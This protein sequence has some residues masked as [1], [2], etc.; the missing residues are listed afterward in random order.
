MKISSQIYNVLIYDEFITSPSDNVV[1]YIIGEKNELV[2]IKHINSPKN[3][4]IAKENVEKFLSLLLNAKRN[5][6]YKIIY[7]C[8][9]NFSLNSINPKKLHFIDSVVIDIITSNPIK[10]V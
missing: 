1:I 8:L 3:N 2:I 5:N 10:T 9:T 6:G 4:I 7:D